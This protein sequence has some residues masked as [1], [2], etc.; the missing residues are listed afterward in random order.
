MQIPPANIVLFLAS[1]LRIV[2]ALRLNHRALTHTIRYLPEPTH[3]LSLNL[4]PLFDSPRA[5]E[6]TLNPSH[7]S[8][9]ICLPGYV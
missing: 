6:Q 9:L 7:P 5:V 3:S 1:S 8:S 4:I 2:D